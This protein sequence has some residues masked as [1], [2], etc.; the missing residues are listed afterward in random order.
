MLLAVDI[1]NTHIHLGLFNGKRLIRDWKLPSQVYLSDKEYFRKIK[2][3]IPKDFQ[4]EEACLASVV[5]DLTRILQKA[6]IRL[7]G[8]IPLIVNQKNTGGLKIKVDRSKEV[9]ADRIVNCLAAYE[10]YGAPA[11]V[12]DF[13]TAITFDLISGKK[14]YLGGVIAPGMELT[15]KA[16][17]LNTALLP[18]VPLGKPRK[19]RGTNTRDCIQSGI[20]YSSIGLSET[21]ISRLKKELKWKNPKIILTGGQAKLISPHLKVSH[22]TDPNL[23]LKGLYTLYSNSIL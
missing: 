12:I 21:I 7:T 20:Y 2:K 4:V 6:L 15:A 13:G 10:L 19:V 9:G 3:Q 5:P 11:I 22:R 16:L 14:E 8:N 1:G 18:E 23:T 17:H